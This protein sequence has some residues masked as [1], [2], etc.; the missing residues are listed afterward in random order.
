VELAGERNRISK[1]ERTVPTDD[2]NPRRPLYG[3]IRRIPDCVVSAFGAGDG[4]RG[5]GQVIVLM[6]ITER[7]RRVGV[8]MIALRVEFSPAREIRAGDHSCS[9]GR[10]QHEGITIARSP[11]QVHGAFYRRQA[12]PVSGLGVEI[13][14]KKETS[15]RKLK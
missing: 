7:D 13:N 3:R 8:A 4:D 11:S 2:G 1:L 14:H 9:F 5:E 12:G 15:V 6:N 10:V